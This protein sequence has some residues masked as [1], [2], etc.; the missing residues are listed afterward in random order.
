[1]KN[2]TITIALKDGTTAETVGRATPCPGLAIT[3][4]RGSY[5]VTHVP[6]GRVVALPSVINTNVTLA[7]I[8]DAMMLATMT[9]MVIGNGRA[10]DWTEGEEALM[11]H[12]D[13]RAACREWCE[14][15]LLHV[16]NGR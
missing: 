13:D 11:A 2:E 6:S 3:G 1:M 16:A 10:V 8:R 14:S 5:T 9:E 4:S 12:K 7:A 15:F